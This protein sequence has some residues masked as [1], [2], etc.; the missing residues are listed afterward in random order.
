MKGSITCPVCEEGKLRPSSYDETLSF[1]GEPLHV[2]GLQRCLCDHCEADPVL[3]EQ[4]AHN[5]VLITDAKRAS[6]NRLGSVEIKALRESLGLTQKQASEI[7]GGGLNAFS[8]YERGEVIQS[9]AMDKLLR[10]ASMLPSIKG[11]LESAEMQRASYRL[12]SKPA[13]PRIR[14]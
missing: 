4:I 5:Q 11:V 2:K 10:L 3:S 6:I 1:N 14:V 12:G 7:F 13:A 8:K 9:E